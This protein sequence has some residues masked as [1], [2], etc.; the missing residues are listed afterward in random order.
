MK[1]YTKALNV[2]RS[3]ATLFKHGDYGAISQATK[4]PDPVPDYNPTDICGGERSMQDETEELDSSASVDVNEERHEN[5]GL[6]GA[7]GNACEVR[8]SSD[9]SADSTATTQLG[10][11]TQLGTQLGVELTQLGPDHQLGTHLG[12]QLATDSTQ[13]GNPSLDRVDQDE[14]P[15]L[16]IDVERLSA[17][18]S[19]ATE[20][21]EVQARS[22]NL[23][24]ANDE[25]E[26]ESPPK[27]K[28]RTKQKPKAV[29][30]RRNRVIAM[31]QEVLEMHDKQLSILSLYE[32]LENKPTFNWSYEQ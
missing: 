20:S 16:G 13:L 2:L 19:S 11:D 28:G 4:Q 22:I 27:S 17:E 6:A 26:L 31:I 15:E 8:A 21:N 14:Q 24:Y 12:T 9:S 5:E 1:E 3:V 18:S 23:A 7:N 32:V 30:A 10:T 25:F 29:K